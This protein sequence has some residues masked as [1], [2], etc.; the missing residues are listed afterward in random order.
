MS[1]ANNDHMLIT[2]ATLTSNHDTGLPQPP[3]SGHTT[4][5]TW[6]GKLDILS[7]TNGTCVR[8]RLERSPKWH[9]AKIFSIRPFLC[10][11]SNKNYRNPNSQS[12]DAHFK[13]KFYQNPFL[14]GLCSGASPRLPQPLCPHCFWCLDLDAEDSGAVIIEC[15]GP[16]RWLNA[17]CKSLIPNDH[18]DRVNHSDCVTAI[19]SIVSIRVI[20]VWRVDHVYHSDSRH[21]RRV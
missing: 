12:S 9:A 13:L 14:A 5:H 17:P 10:I 15:L 19:A 4:R 2:W 21:G 18:F 6:L 1:T 20:N 11:S 3:G 8:P 7:K 16:T